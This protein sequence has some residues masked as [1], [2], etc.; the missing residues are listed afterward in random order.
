[1]PLSFLNGGPPYRGQ[2]ITTLASLMSQVGATLQAGGWAQVLADT[3]A[4]KFRYSCLSDGATA[5]VEINV[6][7]NNLTH[8]GVQGHTISVQGYET[9][10]VLSPVI[11]ET[12]LRFFPGQTN[13]VYLTAGT[14]FLIWAI[15]NPYTAAQTWAQSVY[16]GFLERRN[17]LNTGAWVVGSLNGDYGQIRVARNPLDSSTWAQSWNWGNYPQ[18]L[19]DRDGNPDYE[20]GGTIILNSAYLMLGPYRNLGQFQA[21]KSGLGCLRYGQLLPVPDPD[22][23][24]QTMTYLSLGDSATIQGFQVA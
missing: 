19:T 21:T 11:T 8:Q 2:P 22:N 17:P 15:L 7:L 24:G 1:M 18:T 12:Q 13:Y 6:A 20:T 14:D 4:W 16:V 23:P 9:V 10:G 5:R 3:T